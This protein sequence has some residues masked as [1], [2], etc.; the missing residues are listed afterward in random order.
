MKAV[1]EKAAAEKAAIEEKK[2]AAEKAAEEKKA[3]A[4]KA[5]EEKKATYKEGCSGCWH[6]G[7]STASSTAST[8]KDSMW[9]S[10]RRVH[11]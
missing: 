4:E 3:A 6:Q 2:A 11:S 8:I 1:D 7:A 10:Y 9:V 5:A